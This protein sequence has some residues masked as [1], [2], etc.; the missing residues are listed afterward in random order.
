MERS[1]DAEG[2]TQPCNE[3]GNGA[4]MIWTRLALYL[5]VAIYVLP[6]PLFASLFLIM[7]FRG[8][9]AT[10]LILLPLLLAYAVIALLRLRGR[11]SYIQPP[12]ISELRRR[13]HQ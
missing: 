9:T 2:A 3:Q 13:M 1:A 4:D 8:K 5:L 6:V 7:L 12:P 10:A 11:L